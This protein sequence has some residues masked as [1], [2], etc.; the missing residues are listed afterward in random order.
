M[1]NNEFRILVDMDDVVTNYLEDMVKEYNKIYNTNHSIE[2][3]TEWKIPDS[4]EHGLF[5]VHNVSDVL[6]RVTPKA[7]SIKYINKWIDEG[8]QVYIVSD[9]VNCAK[10]YGEKIKWLQAYL[11]KFDISHFIPC[12][13]KHIVKGDILIDDNLDNLEK[14][15]LENPYGHDL[16][17]TA[18]HNK[19]LQDERRVDSFEEVDDYIKTVQVLCSLRDKVRE[20]R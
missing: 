2:E 9:C 12:S 17:F 1:K 16:L 13:E 5:S 4:F 7:D 19:E 10:R 8:Y 11:P 14:W 20:L 3:I 6:T 15:S 18:Q